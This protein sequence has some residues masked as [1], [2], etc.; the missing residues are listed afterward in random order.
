MSSAKI[1]MIGLE[2][3]LNA[4]NH[5][6]FDNIIIPASIDKDTLVNSILLESAEFEVLYPNPTFMQQSIQLWFRKWNRTFNKWMEALEIKYNPLDNYDRSE[7]W[8]DKSGTVS[9]G[10]VKDESHGKTVDKGETHND[11]S[12]Y[13]SSTYQPSD[14]A[15]SSSD[16]TVDNNTTTTTD[17]KLDVNSSHAGRI[18]GNIGVMSSQEL[19]TKELDVAKFNVYNQIADMFLREFCILIYD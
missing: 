17:S 13:D 4:N 7:E 1:T 16:A 8:T 6:L 10:T 5:S 18:H 12:A 19:L 3:Y 9:G 11:V 2:T 14:H 15:T